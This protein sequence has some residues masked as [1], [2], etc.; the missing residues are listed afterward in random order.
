MVVYVSVDAWVRFQSANIGNR[1]SLIPVLDF[2]FQLSIF[3]HEVSL[4]LR[5]NCPPKSLP[6]PGP[7][8]PAKS[9]VNKS[10]SAFLD[11]VRIGSR[12]RLV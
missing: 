2:F 4:R 9:L 5:G 10:V 6:P 7:D 8:A 1:L 12:A 11:S 3:F